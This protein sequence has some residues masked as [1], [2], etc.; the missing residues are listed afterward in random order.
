LLI[1]AAFAWASPASALGLYPALTQS[2]LGVALWG[3]QDLAWE[4][5]PSALADG[6]AWDGKVGQASWSQ[7][8]DA[9]GG[10]WRAQSL[11]VSLAK[12]LADEGGVGLRYAQAS[13]DQS[14]ALSMS[15]GTGS[16]F[17]LGYGWAMGYGLSAGLSLGQASTDL[18]GQGGRQDALVG[19]GVRWAADG[20]ILATNGLWS[21]ESLVRAAYV[22]AS[23]GLGGAWS[24]DASA[25]WEAGTLQAALVALGFGP[26]RIYDRYTTGH[27]PGLAW[28]QQGPAWGLQAMVDYSTVEQL[29][30]RVALNWRGF[31]GEYFFDQGVG[32][33][34]GWHSWAAPP[35]PAATP[36]PVENVAPAIPDVD[37]A[38]AAPSPADL[39]AD[40]AAE[41][42]AGN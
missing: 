4:D 33:N 35:A 5:D 3:P 1:V 15:N 11:Y 28:I 31:H 6:P 40:P 9:D 17:G 24:Y 27:G 42:P 22:G 19:L 41:K 10:T 2:R 13:A 37:P 36:E 32:M 18:Q 21:K 34:A 29:T 7:P 26:L 38:P 12:G 39:K 8:K 25:Q 20:Q 23:G 14:S 16:A 30:G